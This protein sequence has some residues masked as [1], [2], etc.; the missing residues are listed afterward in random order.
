V[1]PS[2]CFRPLNLHEALDEAYGE[3]ED[4]AAVRAVMASAL[5]DPRAKGDPHVFDYAWEA[6]EFYDDEL[7]MAAELLAK[8]IEAHP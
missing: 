1:L 7:P 4:A 2:H 3:D 8:L 6:I 5:L